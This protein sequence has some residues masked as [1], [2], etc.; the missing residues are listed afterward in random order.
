MSALALTVRS[1]IPEGNRVRLTSTPGRLG[2]SKATSALAGTENPTLVVEPGRNK[3][4]AGGLSSG[5]G[6]ARSEGPR[7]SA[8]IASHEGAAARR[9]GWLFIWGADTI[10]PAQN[11]WKRP[12]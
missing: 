1:T 9:R 2:G 12:G 7:S 10:F 11:P 4:E 6:T 5:T 3:R 8:N